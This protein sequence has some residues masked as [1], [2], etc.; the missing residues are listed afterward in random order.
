MDLFGIVEVFLCQ[1]EEISCNQ[2]M[3]HYKNRTDIMIKAQICCTN[4]GLVPT[5]DNADTI[6]NR[7]HQTMS[8]C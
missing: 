4:N 3:G 8:F 5:D 7:K 1:I 2:Y 6:E